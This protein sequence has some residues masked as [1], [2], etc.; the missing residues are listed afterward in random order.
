MSNTYLSVAMSMPNL[1]FRTVFRV[2]GDPAAQVRMI[3]NQRMRCFQDQSGFG[4]K[5]ASGLKK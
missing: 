3:P 5:N 4:S 1:M 2:L